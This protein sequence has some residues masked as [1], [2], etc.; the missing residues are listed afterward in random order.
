VL[1]MDSSSAS[2]KWTSDHTRA[3]TPAIGQLLSRF[4]HGAHVDDSRFSTTGNYSIAIAGAENSMVVSYDAGIPPVVTPAAYAAF[5]FGEMS[6]R[7]AV[8]TGLAE[9]ATW[10]I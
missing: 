5:R 7:H 2:A 3:L 10:R 9:P 8:Y 1:L 6:A 4:M